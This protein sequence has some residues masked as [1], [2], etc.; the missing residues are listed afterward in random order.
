MS[1]G[2]IQKMKVLGALENWFLG[3]QNYNTYSTT[4]YDYNFRCSYLNVFYEA[5]VFAQVAARSWLKSRQI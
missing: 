5:V 3:T 4:T 1:Y 2:D